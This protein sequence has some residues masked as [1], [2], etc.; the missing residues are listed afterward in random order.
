MPKK[1]VSTKRPLPL[2]DTLQE[3][4]FVTEI[5]SGKV[6]IVIEVN[7]SKKTISVQPQSMGVTMWNKDV[8]KY[9]PTQKTYATYRTPA[10]PQV[11]AKIYPSRF[12]KRNTAR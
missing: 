5:S 8:S 1:K 4:D 2:I 6:Y 7:R 12:P 3:K 11:P 10:V 9:E